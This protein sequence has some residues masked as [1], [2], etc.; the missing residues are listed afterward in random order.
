[1]S[2]ASLCPRLRLSPS[3][4]PPTAVVA[5]AVVAGGTILLA[6]GFGARDEDGDKKKGIPGGRRAYRL[7]GKVIGCTTCS[8]TGKKPCLFCK[9]SKRMAGF[10]GADVAC[11][12]CDAKGTMGRPCVDCGG[13]GFFTP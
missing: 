11:V 13:M 2:A 10:L 5:V 1:M 3:V 6:R 9:G 12:P 8:G 4:F 7:K